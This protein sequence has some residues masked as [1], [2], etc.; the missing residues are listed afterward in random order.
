[1]KFEM[2]HT[3]KNISKKNHTTIIVKLNFNK[4]I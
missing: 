3:K 2:Q 4:T 1:M